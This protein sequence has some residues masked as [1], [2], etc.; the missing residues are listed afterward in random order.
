MIAI[1]SHLFKP[2]K[3]DLYRAHIV[4]ELEDLDEKGV[5]GIGLLNHKTPNM[6]MQTQSIPSL[7][8][9]PPMSVFLDTPA[10]H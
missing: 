10:N 2:E 1:F 9:L 3:V 4:S 5:L 6:N 8:S 7:I